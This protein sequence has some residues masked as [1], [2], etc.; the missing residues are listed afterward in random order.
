MQADRLPAMDNNAVL[1]TTAVHVTVLADD[2]IWASRLRAAIANAGFEPAAVRRAQD[3]HGGFAVIDLTGRGYDG[4]EAVRVA[5]SAGAT[6]LA[7]GQHDDVNVRKAA[8]AAGAKRVLSY[9]KL[10]NDGPAVIS[11]LVEGTL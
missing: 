6:V 2:L 11:R 5:A 3:I 4:V 10:F 1:S 9:N 8:L 7:V